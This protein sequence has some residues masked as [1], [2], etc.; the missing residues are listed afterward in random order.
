MDQL[1]SFHAESAHAMKF[2]RISLRRCIAFSLYSSDVEQ[3][4]ALQI[5]SIAQQPGQ[6]LH[7]M[8]INWPQVSKAHVF[9]QTTGEQSLF[10]CGLY[11]MGHIVNVP[12]QRQD[13]HYL[14]VSLLKVQILGLQPLT[15][16]MVRHT[17]YTLCDGHTVVVQDDDQRFPTV[18]CI[19]Q[20]F[21]GQ[22]AGQR[23][24]T[25]QCQHMII[26]TL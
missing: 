25:D 19:G 26:R 4:R 11:F 17:T 1:S 8:S 5:L 10:D 12:A 14:A 24:V 22:T 6:A 16:Q 20:A 15:G 23:A 7:I 2:V 21:I 3:H 9:K 18:A 13:A